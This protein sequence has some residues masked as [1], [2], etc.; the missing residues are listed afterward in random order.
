[1][2][3][4]REDVEHTPKGKEG[5][6]PDR[7]YPGDGPLSLR[8]FL[9]PGPSAQ[10]RPLNGDGLP[11]KRLPGGAQAVPRGPEEVAIEAADVANKR[12]QRICGPTEGR[13]E[14]KGGRG[15]TK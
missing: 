5:A 12:G 8:E 4:G 15:E 6:F 1:M 13:P 2:V 11:A 3:P 7:I 10:L 14:S 9:R